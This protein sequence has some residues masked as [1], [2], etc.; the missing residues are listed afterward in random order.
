MSERPILSDTSGLT[1]L[2]SPTSQPSKQLESFPF[3]HKNRTTVT[4]HCEEFTCHCPLTGQPDYARLDIEYV[5]NDRALESKSLR[6]YLW[7]FRDAGVFHEDAANIILDELFEFL[8][9]RCMKVIAQFRIR[10]GIAIDVTAE[11][12][13]E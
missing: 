12:S 1:Q 13:A 7:S 8:K 6:N 5:P 4:F 10:G 2:G 11:R 9:P 3:R